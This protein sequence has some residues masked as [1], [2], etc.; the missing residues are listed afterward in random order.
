MERDPRNIN[1]Y[2]LGAIGREMRKR[3]ELKEAAHR[4]LMRARLEREKELAAIGECPSPYDAS[5]AKDFFD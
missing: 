5:R 3:R 1:A 2:D 4:T